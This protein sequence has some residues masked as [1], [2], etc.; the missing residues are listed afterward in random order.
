MKIV[1]YDKAEGKIRQVFENANNVKVDGD[2]IKWDDGRIRGIGCDFAVIPDE[3]DHNDLSVL[4][5]FDPSRFETDEKKEQK[6]LD[7]IEKMI[8][9]ILLNK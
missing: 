4:D 1:L 3:A 2:N 9:F 8:N 7:Q 6:R 5:D